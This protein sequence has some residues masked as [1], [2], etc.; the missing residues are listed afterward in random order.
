MDKDLKVVLLLDYYGSLL[1]L[2]Q[3]RL[4]EAYYCDDL[5]LTEISDNEGITR[6]GARD[7]IVRA[8]AK[9]R[10]YEEAVGF[11][12]KATHIKSLL[13]E[14]EE[15]GNSELLKKLSDAIHDM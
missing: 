8:V 9:L 1:P 13:D 5:S 3:K 7:A 10:K 4:V 15:K 6:Q 2:K 12:N 14:Y 11:V